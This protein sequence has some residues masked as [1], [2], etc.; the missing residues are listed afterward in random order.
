MKALEFE[1]Q[2]A[3]FAKD[4]KEYM[5]LP[6]HVQ[7][8][9]LVT[10]CMQLSDEE[11]EGVKKTKKL[12]LSVLTFGRPVQPIRISTA[13]PE[14]PIPAIGR[15]HCNPVSCGEGPT[16]PATLKIEL[17]PIQLHMIKAT[18]VFWVTVATFGTP[19]QPITYKNWVG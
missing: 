12:K 2:N 18:G 10:F 15:F 6:A 1:Q 13:T 7:N 14:F 17:L 4:Q 19:L 5:P 11:I 3:V 16:A 8:N 9:G